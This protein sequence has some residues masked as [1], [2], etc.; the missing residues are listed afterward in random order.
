[1][2]SNWSYLGHSIF[3]GS[4]LLAILVVFLMVHA[5]RNHRKKS[6]ASMKIALLERTIT[7]AVEL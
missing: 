2:E 3:V 7:G 4:V 5:Y 6:L 1:M